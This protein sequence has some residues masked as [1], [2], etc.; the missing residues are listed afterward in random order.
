MCGVF[1]ECCLVRCTLSI[2]PRHVVQFV[3]CDGNFI[4]FNNKLDK[5][6]E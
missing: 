1:V 5:L 6:P 2:L 3:D 4:Y